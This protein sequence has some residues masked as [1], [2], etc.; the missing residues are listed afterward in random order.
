[1]AGMSVVDVYRRRAAG[2]AALVVAS[3]IT[4]G[5]PAAFGD[6]GERKTLDEC[7]A[8]ALAQQP[9][10]RSADASVEAARERV[11]QSAAAYLPQVTANYNANR[12]STTA[13]NL[14]GGG[15]SFTGGAG[16]RQ[17]TFNFFSTGVALSQVLFDFGQNLALVHRAKALQSSAA[18]DADTQ[19]DTVVFDVSQSYFGLLAAYRLRDVS[20]ETVRQNQQHLDLAQGR[21]EVG[22]A[23]K[24]D[25]TQAQVQLAQAELAQVTARNNVTLGRETLRN[26]LGLSGPLAFDIVDVLEARPVSLDDEAAVDLAFANRPELR[27]IRA[28]RDAAVQQIAA[29]QKDY[30]PKVNGS[31]NYTFSGSSYP[32]QDNWNIGASVNLS[33]FNGGLTTAQVGEAR[34]NLS[35]IEA[36]EESLRQNVELEVRQAMANVQQGRESVRVADKANRQAHENVELAEGRYATGAG[37]IIELT[38]AQASLASAEA[39]LV[40]A[41]VNYRIAVA[42]LERATGQRFE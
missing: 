23:P 7:I 10:L 37:S 19:R 11:W 17:Q 21:F 35:V 36:N 30:L 6:G 14:T 9:T 1:M 42:S 33:V 2:I 16:Q 8:L 38:D 15:G 41:R 20:D 32:L 3:G 26:A 22:F 39:S 25:V 12:R 28:Q 13:G 24:F 29:I 27:S 4:I 18:A 31:A 5:P 34:A 40:Q